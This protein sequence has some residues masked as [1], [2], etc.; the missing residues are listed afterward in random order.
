VSVA[1]STYQRKD[2]I[3][4]LI[5]ALGR[6][7]LPPSDFE[8]VVYDDASGDGTPAL[9]SELAGSAP[10]ALRIVRGEHNR[11]PASGRNIA[12]RATRAPVVAFIDDDCVPDPGWLEAGLAGIADSAVG[13]V[14]G[15]VIPAPDQAENLGP[16]ARTL[17]VDDARFFATANCFY[18]RD[19][20][21]VADGFDERFRRA[22]GEDTDLG[23]RVQATGAQTAFAPSALV[24]HD[25]RPSQWRAAAREA[26]LKWV[27]LALVVR[28]HPR[29]RAEL[30][31]GRIFW[32]KEHALLLLAI[33]GVATAW[34]CPLT[35]VALVPYLYRRLRTVPLARGWRAVTTLPGAVALD[36]L[37]LGTMVRSSVRYRCLIL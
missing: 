4:R 9:L 19:L 3:A 29:I 35:L 25:V 22:A 26:W 12:W 20:L 23:L 32:K 31:W 14:V 6:Q 21:E 37:E 2:R 15:R 7:S 28:K 5:D 36:L 13:V 8:V 30:L 24:C 16:Y 18:R 11:G 1:V 33:A 17:R 34:W 10:F 27:D